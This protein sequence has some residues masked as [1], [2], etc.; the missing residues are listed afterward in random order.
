MTAMTQKMERLMR[1]SSEHTPAAIPYSSSFRPRPRLRKLAG[2]VVKLIALGLPGI[3]TQLP[4]AAALRGAGD[5]RFPLIASA[6][7]IWIFRVAVA[8]V[9]VYTF[10]WGLYGAWITI[11]LD[12]TVRA[13]VVYGRFL[14]GKWMYM[15]TA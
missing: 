4:V 13:L 14:T 8:P 6:L 3:Y 11:V 1:V 5:A 7:G 10:G 15:K 2:S 9:F 12:Q